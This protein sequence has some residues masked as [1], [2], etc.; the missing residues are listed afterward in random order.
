MNAIY[1]KSKTKRKYVR[2]PL[3]NNLNGVCTRDTCRCN[4][5]MKDKLINK[6]IDE[7]LHHR[8]KVIKR[9]REI[10][11]MKLDNELVEKV[12]TPESKIKGLKPEKKPKYFFWTF[13]GIIT[14]PILW[15]IVVLLIDILN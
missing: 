6:K 4:Y 7:Y 12:W 11:L 2:K 10:D 15:V 1:Q 5:S 3:C 8:E 9:R 13:I 14:I